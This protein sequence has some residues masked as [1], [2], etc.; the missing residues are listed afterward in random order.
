[1]T[2]E[3]RERIDARN[4]IT[5]T[6]RDLL[7]ASMEIGGVCEMACWASSAVAALIDSTGKKVDDLTVGE[8][9]K[10]LDDDARDR[11]RR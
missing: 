8:L 5:P 9:R 2:N 1:M 6:H 7:D 11:S 4:G 3:E 10:L